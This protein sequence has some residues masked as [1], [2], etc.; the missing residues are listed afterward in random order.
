MWEGECLSRVY[1]TTAYLQP[2]EGTGREGGGGAWIGMPTEE[3]KKYVLQVQSSSSKLN[4]LRVTT[5]DFC[6]LSHWTGVQR[7]CF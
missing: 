3:K 5:G 1:A 4:A 7:T 6:V 2:K